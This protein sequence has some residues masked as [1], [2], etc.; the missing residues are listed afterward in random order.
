MTQ[1]QI[2]QSFDGQFI[3]HSKQTGSSLDE[4][5]KYEEIPAFRT[6]YRGQNENEWW[7]G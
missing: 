7:E 2:S 4:E 3:F 6:M 5:N 1:G